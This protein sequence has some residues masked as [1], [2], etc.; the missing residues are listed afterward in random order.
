[1]KNLEIN[2]NNQLKDMRSRPEADL[3]DKQRTINQLDERIN[4]ENEAKKTQRTSFLL[5]QVS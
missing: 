5:N 2:M 1:M 4:R 3:D